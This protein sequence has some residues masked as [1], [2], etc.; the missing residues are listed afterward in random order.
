MATEEILIAGI[1]YKV[2]K[3]IEVNNFLT[4]EN[5]RLLVENEDSAKKLEDL[6]K[7]IEENQKEIFKFTLANT[8]ETE[9]GVEEGSKRIDS[10]IDEI[11]RCIEMLGE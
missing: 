11:N 7:K 3:L 1:E 8:L 2:K 4:Q 9:F 5:Q 10:L 6:N